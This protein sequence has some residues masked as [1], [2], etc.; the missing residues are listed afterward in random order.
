MDIHE[1]REAVSRAR[2]NAIRK[3][4][5]IEKSDNYV[6]LEGSKYYP[7]RP[8]HAHD[9]YTRRQLE[10]YLS[11]LQ[12]FI[13]IRTQF[14][15][16]H[17]NNPIPKKKWQQYKKQE[18]VYN[19]RVEEFSTKFD[20]KVK[21]RHDEVE[22]SHIYRMSNPDHMAGNSARNGA[23]RRY[24]R[25]SRQIMG[26]EKLS[27]LTKKLADELS[28][29]RLR[30]EMGSNWTVVRDIL[31]RYA[32]D[33]GDELVELFKSLSAEQFEYFW[34]FSPE[35]VH[36][37]FLWYETIKAMDEGRDD[38]H[39]SYYE[40]YESARENVVEFMKEVKQKVQGGKPARVNRWGYMQPSYRQPK[41]KTKKSSSRRKKK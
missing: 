27:K 9:K 17:K 15:P 33:T 41:G 20:N 40:L 14:V 23:K 5:R 16:D 26:E 3:K 37:F 34:Y 1:L 28:D 29:K 13:S 21:L 19:Q 25:K 22:P 24:I 35:H 11:N 4:R 32:D 30:K 36:E 6:K 7:V 31:Y 8:P 39:A 10:V 18:A 38:L 12:E 2:R